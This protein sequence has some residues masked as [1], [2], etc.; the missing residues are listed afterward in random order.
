MVLLLGIG[1]AENDHR[2]PGDLC[3]EF[4][5]SGTFAA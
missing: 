4:A 1:V 5:T 3:E 2:L